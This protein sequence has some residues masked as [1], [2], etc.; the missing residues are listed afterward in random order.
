MPFLPPPISC[1]AWGDL[2]IVVRNHKAT[3]K[4]II[5]VSRLPWHTCKHRISLLPVGSQSW[6]GWTIQSRHSTDVCYWRW[7]ISTRVTAQRG[8]NA[9]RRMT[10]ECCKARHLAGWLVVTLCC[11]MTGRQ[12]T[13]NAAT[14]SRFSQGCT[15]QARRREYFRSPIASQFHFLETVNK[16]RQNFK[17]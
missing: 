17:F 5:P 6:H 11:S 4:E 13:A 7:V 16:Y 8:F 2:S 12:A 14:R 3:Q 1:C 9:T 15:H 10:W